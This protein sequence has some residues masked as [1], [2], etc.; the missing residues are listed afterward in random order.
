MLLAAGAG[1]T[2]SCKVNDYCLECSPATAVTVT[3]RRTVGDGGTVDGNDGDAGPCINTGVEICDGKDN[4]C[5][6]LIDDGTLPEVGDACGS[7]M[8]ACARAV[9]QCV[10]GAI[11]CSKN[12]S[13]E[14]CNNIDD[15]CDGVVDNGDPGGG[16]KCGTNQGECVTGT[17][18]CN[19]N[20]HIVTCGIRCGTGTA[21]DCPVGILLAVRATARR[22]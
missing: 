12:P 21:V 4:D 3:A 8:G 22:P 18:H 11:K 19:P 7:G 1:A 15:D 14:Q 17:L 9:K 2:L 10:N 6:G 13:A 20:S 5:N 16:A